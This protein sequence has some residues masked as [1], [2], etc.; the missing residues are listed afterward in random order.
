MMCCRL[1]ER[2]DFL[3]ARMREVHVRVLDM[4]SYIFHAASM[5]VKADFMLTA[6]PPEGHPE[7]VSQ[8]EPRLTQVSPTPVLAMVRTADELWEVAARHAAASS[9]AQEAEKG[10]TGKNKKAAAAPPSRVRVYGELDPGYP[11]YLV[12]Y[13]NVSLGPAWGQ[14]QPAAAGAAPRAKKGQAAGPPR[15]CLPLWGDL[16][17]GGSPLDMPQLDLATPGGAASHALP[18]WLCCV[19]KPMHSDAFPEQQQCHQPPVLY[20]ALLAQVVVCAQR[21]QSFSLSPLPC[22]GCRLRPPPPPACSTSS[23]PLEGC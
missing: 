10:R 19:L 7:R 20:A 11:T 5:D 18:E 22:P 17:I 8:M 1:A 4:H 13:A 12:L 14:Q 16:A 23:H 9:E 6:L 21:V 2:A 3:R 15:A